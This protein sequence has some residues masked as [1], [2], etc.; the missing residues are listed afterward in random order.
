MQKALKWALAG[1]GIFAGYKLLALK[2]AADRLRITP[3]R[4]NFKGVRSLQA[5]F[6]LVVDAANP[7][8]TTIFLNYIYLDIYAPS[9]KLAQVRA[10]SSTLG[11]RFPLNANSVTTLTIPFQVGIASLVLTLGKAAVDA[12]TG[13]KLPD[14]LIVQGEVKANGVAQKWDEKIPF[15]KTAPAA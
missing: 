14:S 1:A 12:I 11:E 10:D 13:G 15:K 6:E 3:T 2:S 5:Q 9:G 8:G 7:S 4:A